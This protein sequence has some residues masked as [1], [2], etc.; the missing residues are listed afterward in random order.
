MSFIR[1]YLV[2]RRDLDGNNDPV[3]DEDVDKLLTLTKPAE[4]VN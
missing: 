2:K 1:N 3:T 4:L